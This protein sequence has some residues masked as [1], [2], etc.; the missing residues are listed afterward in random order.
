M[1]AGPELDLAAEVAHQ[2]M[3]QGGVLC[4]G[5]RV[6]EEGSSDCPVATFGVELVGAGSGIDLKGVPERLAVREERDTAQLK[7]PL[8][9]GPG[10][11]LLVLARHLVL[12]EVKADDVVSPASA[13]GVG[14][15]GNVSVVE[16]EG[17]MQQ[18]LQR[19]Q[20]SSA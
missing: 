16:H 13:N 6:V 14:V 8:V 2:R 18:F 20:T 12:G 17:I 15:R 4:M 7:E 1:M 9:L 11:H 5:R 3:V 10:P 19:R